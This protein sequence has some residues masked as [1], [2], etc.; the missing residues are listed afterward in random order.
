MINSIEKF[1]DGCK[2]WEDCKGESGDFEI[3]NEKPICYRYV[4]WRF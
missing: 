1:C 2:Y 4:P 3:I